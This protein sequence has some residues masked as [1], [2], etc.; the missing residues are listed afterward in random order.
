[1]INTPTNSSSFNFTNG[2]SRDLGTLKANMDDALAYVYTHSGTAKQLLDDARNLGITI[3]FVRSV[4][5]GALFHSESGSKDANGAAIPARS[6]AAN[7]IDWDIT[8]AASFKTTDGKVGVM[9]SMDFLLHEIKHAVNYAQNPV[10]FKSNNQSN[11][12]LLN[13]TEY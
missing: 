4:D 5:T 12:S 11:T 8:N 3:N 2:T 1:M 7:S 13:C 10:A 6:W 9:S